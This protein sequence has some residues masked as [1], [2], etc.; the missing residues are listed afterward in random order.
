MV[1]AKK[2]NIFVKRARVKRSWL[3][4]SK[5]RSFRSHTAARRTILTVVVLVSMVVVLA[6]L[7]SI[8]N[9]PERVV[10]GKIEEIARDYYENYYYAEIVRAAETSEKTAEEILASSAERGIP[11]INLEQLLLYG[12][13]RHKDVR[14]TLRRYCDENG[15]V[16]TIYPEEPYGQKDYRLEI[17]YACNF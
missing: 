15:T 7:F 11:K 3:S 5:A 6:V 14:A 9:T 16:A 1:S 2:K 8:F 13:G 10:T 17:N 4:R 12:N